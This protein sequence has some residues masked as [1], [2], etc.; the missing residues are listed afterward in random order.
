MPQDIEVWIVGILAL[1][2]VVA[3]ALWLGRQFRLVVSPG[4]GLKFEVR[5]T[6]EKKKGASTSVLAGAELRRTQVQEIVGHSVEGLQKSA[7]GDTRVL[8]QATIAD[9]KIGRIVGRSERQVQE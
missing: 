6:T 4:S 1:A 7:T 5:S 3:L 2:G 9:S 8:D